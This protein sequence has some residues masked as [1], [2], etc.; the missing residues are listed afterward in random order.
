MNLLWFFTRQP[1]TASRSAD[2]SKVLGSSAP[3]WVL[4]ITAF[5]LFALGTWAYFAEIDQVSRAPGIVIASSR[6][7]IIQSQEGGTL[8]ELLVKEGDVVEKDTVLA[9]LERTKAESSFLEARAKAAGLRAAVARL[10]AEIY[11]GEPKFPPETREYAEFRA[12]QLA[13]FQKRRAAIRQ[14]IAALERMKTLV[15]RELELNKPLL[16][17]GDVSETDV[18]RL[19]RQLADLQA[20]ITN[21]DNKYFQDAQA[22]LN[23]AQEDLAGIEQTLAQRAN[24]LEQT[25]LRAPLRGVVKNVRITT[26]GGVIR[27][28]EE[29]MQIVPLEDDLAIEARIDPADIAFV[30][31]GQQTSVKIDAYDYTIYGGLVGKLIFISADTLTE[32][33]KQGEKP[34]YRARVQTSGKQFSGRPDQTLDILPGM[35]A[36]IEIK[37]GRNTVLRYL[38]KPITKTLNESMGER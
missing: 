18:L 25:E 15:A 36:T 24:V 27:P 22:E 23:K 13:L 28:G 35:T 37:T 3:H 10:N 17:S 9:R 14:E 16:R 11:G 8:N 6:S 38:T 30:K 29:V 21:K 4:W 32:D 2:R 1:D 33:L 34:Y 5:S 26:R 12:N 20:Q 31:I 7:Q 19:E